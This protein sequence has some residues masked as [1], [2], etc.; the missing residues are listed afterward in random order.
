M[1]A[2]HRAAFGSQDDGVVALL[3]HWPP[4]RPGRQCCHSWQGAMVTSSA[5]GGVRYAGLLE[6]PR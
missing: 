2:I 5:Q 4:T 1:D 3:H 6:K